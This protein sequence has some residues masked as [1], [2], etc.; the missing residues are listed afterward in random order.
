M[1]FDNVKNCSLYYGSHENFKK[2]FDFILKAVNENLPVGKYEIDGNNVYATVL[3]YVSFDYEKAKFEGHRKYIDIQFIVSGTE[4]ILVEDIA[5]SKINSEY[6]DAID[7]EFYNDSQDACAL[8]LNAGDFA[9]LFPHDIH[10]PSLKVT[11]PANVKKIVVKVK[12]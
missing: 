3:E 5:S 8:I 1:I 9:V 6:K 7:I 4:K 2:A 11:E 12:V 10:K